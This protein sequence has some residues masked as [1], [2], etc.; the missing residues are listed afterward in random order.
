MTNI[1]RYSFG[2]NEDINEDLNGDVVLYTDH[3]AALSAK[4]QEN[5]QLRGGIE[6]KQ[7]IIE[8]MG[9]H[10]YDADKDNKDLRE[11]LAAS[12][13]DSERLQS[14][15]FSIAICLKRANESG[16]INDTIWFSDAQTL[17]DYIDSNTEPLQQSALQQLSD[18]GQARG[19]YK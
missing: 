10:I 3:L 11:R 6:A 8:G 16:I 19:E 1:Q 5:K 14:A 2:T 15:L 17:F 18:E 4:D 13:A 7:K 9:K 12:S